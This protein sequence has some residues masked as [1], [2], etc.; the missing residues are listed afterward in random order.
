MGKPIVISDVIE[1]YRDTVFRLAF[2]YRQ[3]HT[4]LP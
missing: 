1:R 4:F 2:T 3:A